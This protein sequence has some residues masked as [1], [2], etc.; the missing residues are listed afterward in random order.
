MAAMFG[1]REAARA[2][3]TVEAMITHSFMEAEM[4]A[5]FDAAKASVP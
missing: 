3:Q 2:P 5:M 1:S 4:A